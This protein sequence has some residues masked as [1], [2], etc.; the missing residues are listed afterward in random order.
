M[1]PLILTNHQCGPVGG[2]HGEE[3][4]QYDQPNC[5]LCADSNS[6]LFWVAVGGGISKAQAETPAPQVWLAPIQAQKGVSGAGLLAKKFDEVSRSQM[7]SSPRVKMSEQLSVA[8]ISAGES[9]PRVE[10]AD[11]FRVAG[12]EAYLAKNY[13]LALQRLKVA[14]EKYEAALPSV[15]KFNVVIETLGYLGA[16][17]V[18]SSLDGDAKEYFRQVVATLPNAEPLDEYSSK[19][20]AYFAKVRKKLGFERSVDGS[21]SR[22]NRLVQK[23]A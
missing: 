2:V 13:K 18:D 6:G 1:I 23:S 12:K 19:A 20:K 21:K 22:P 15:S 10:E 11:S 14:L 8:S 4:R 9:D 3:K 5:L 7:T 16:A 17:S